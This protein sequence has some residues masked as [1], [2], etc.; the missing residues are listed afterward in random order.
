MV[1]SL[2]SASMSVKP[3]SSPQAAKTTTKRSNR[4]P[5]VKVISNFGHF[6][7]VVRKDLEFLK[8]GVG[9]GI[10]WANEAFHLPKVSKTVDEVLW[11]RNLEDPEAALIE[12]PDWPQPS[13]P[14]L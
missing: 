3:P 1:V 9:K 2:A 5:Q 8:K 10:A 6:R 12:S 11:L 7:E 14:G 4:R 13:Y